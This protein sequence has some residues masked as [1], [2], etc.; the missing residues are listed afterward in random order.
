MT[1][2]TPMEQKLILTEVVLKAA[3]LDWIECAKDYDTSARELTRDKYIKD[4]CQEHTGNLL[5]IA[6]Y[7]T[8]PDSLSY[9]M[10]LLT[11]SNFGDKDFDSRLR[12]IDTGKMTKDRYYELKQELLANQQDGHDNLIRQKDI[13][14]YLRN[15]VK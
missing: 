11:I 10:Y 14:K 8:N 12:E 5:E 4:F 7:F 1:D 3:M 2:K 15:H 9:L 13:V 6:G